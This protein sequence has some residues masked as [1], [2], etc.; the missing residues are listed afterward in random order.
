MLLKASRAGQ[1][2][3]DTSSSAPSSRDQGL[4]CHLSSTKAWR[5]AS[6]TSPTHAPSPTVDW[7]MSAG[8]VA[9]NTQLWSVILQAQSPH[10]VNNFNHYLA[11]HPDR[12]WSESLLQGI[13]ERLDIGYQGDRKM[14]WSGNWKLALDNR[15]V[16]SKYL[17]TEVALGRKAGLFN[18]PPFHT[19]FGSQLGIVIKK[20][21]DSVK[22]HIIHDLSWLP[23]DSVNDHINPDLYCCVYASFDQAVSLV[24]KHGMGALMEKLDLADAF[25]HILRTDHL[26]AAPGMQPYQ[27]AQ[28]S[29]STTLIYFLPFG[30]HS[31][32]AIFNQCTDVLQFTIQANGISDLLH[33]LD[34]YFMAG[35]ARSGKCQHNVNTMVKVCRELGFAV[36]PSKVRYPSPITC[37]LSIDIDSCKG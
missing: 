27:T 24:K 3:R 37:F 4:N 7:S 26:Y 21:L 12:Q 17:V 29:R 33:Y 31:S 36:I 32:P 30:I 6:S 22:Y 35:P 10:N 13:H 34:K 8:I 5:S 15:S 11:C 2:I 9:R 20:H 16:I 14:V 28:S 18:Q 19:Y 25:K 23:R 1:P